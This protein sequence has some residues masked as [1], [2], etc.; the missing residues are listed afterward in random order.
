MG[1]EYKFKLDQV[2]KERFETDI[3]GQT[4]DVVLR[5]GP[6]IH[7]TNGTIYEYLPQNATENSWR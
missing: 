4:L 5:K 2:D 3:S 1:F 6:G 7:S